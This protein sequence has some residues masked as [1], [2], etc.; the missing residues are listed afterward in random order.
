LNDLADLAETVR[1][2]VV[3]K[4]EDLKNAVLNLIPSKKEILDNDYF[5]DEAPKKPA[6]KAAKKK[7]KK[8]K[9]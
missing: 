4:I 1:W 7:S 6:K 2:T 9:K 8:S 3:W 5:V